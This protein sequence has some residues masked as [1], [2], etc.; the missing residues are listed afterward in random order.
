MPAAL[1][2]LGFLAGCGYRLASS[3][4]AGDGRTIAVPTFVNNTRTYRIEQKMSEALR[5]EL[6]RGTRYNV[7][8]ERSGDVVVAGEVLD[9]STTT[10]VTTEQGRAYEYSMSVA[11]K[12]VVTDT[13]SGA[14][15]FRADNM[16]MRDVFQLAQSSSD[17]VPEDSAALDRL[18]SRFAASIVAS[19]LHRVR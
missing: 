10:V 8:P 14:V 18:A 16:S 17:F 4:N 1:V 5:R 15:L 12:V 19:L 6:T 7:T 11:L 2:L 9:Y 13:R 3:A